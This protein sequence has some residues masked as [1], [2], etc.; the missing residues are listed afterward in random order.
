[1]SHIIDPLYLTQKPDIHK[2]H[3]TQHFHPHNC[4]E[5]HQSYISINQRP[6]S[7]SGWHGFG[8]TATTNGAIKYL[9]VRR[10][11]I[12]MIACDKPNGRPSDATHFRRLC[13]SGGA[14]CLLSKS[15]R[16][17]YIIHFH[18]VPFELTLSL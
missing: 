9:H 10:T 4:T 3:W 1:M 15:F 5:S 16:S 2:S 8:I 6:R 13:P 11:K 14:T 7:D 12:N 18:S 17:S